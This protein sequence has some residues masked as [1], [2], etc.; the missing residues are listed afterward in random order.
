MLFFDKVCNRILL[1]YR[2]SKHVKEGVPSCVVVYDKLKCIW[3]LFTSSLIDKGVVNLS[4]PELLTSL[5]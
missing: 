5:R 2:S 3:L 1:L 4:V